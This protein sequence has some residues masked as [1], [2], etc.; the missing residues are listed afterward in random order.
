[1]PVTVELGG[2]EDLVPVDA[3]VA[4]A[5]THAAFVAVILGR[6][7]QAVAHT[8]RAR[9]RRGGHGVI[10]RPGAEPQSGHFNTVGQRKLRG[11]GELHGDL[12]LYMGCGLC[13]VCMS[14]ACAA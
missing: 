13:G 11:G 6:I 4:D 2:H 8:Q 14:R 1:M 12:L 5:L 10:H 9:D 7:D 3:G